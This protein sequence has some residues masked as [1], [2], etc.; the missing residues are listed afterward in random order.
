MRLLQ[1]LILSLTFVSAVFGQYKVELK[2]SCFNTSYDD[3]A[4]RII[5]NQL[6]VQS[7]AINPCNDAD[8]DEFAKNHFRISI[9]WKD[10]SW[11]LPN[12]KRMLKK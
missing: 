12:F 6:Y 3:F 2:S 7:A 1:T 8:M 5:G 4:T 9:L 10:V 11:F